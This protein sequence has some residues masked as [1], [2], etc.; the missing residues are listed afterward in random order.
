MRKGATG[1]EERV[2]AE[3]G[4]LLVDKGAVE[5]RWAEYFE[6]LL[7]VEDLNEDEVVIVAVGRED[8]VNVLG[9]INET[10]ITRQEVVGALGGMKAGKAAGMD[11][12]AVECLKAA[13]ESGIEWLVRLLNICFVA[14]AVPLDW[15]SACVV[16]LYKGKGDRFACSSFR[17]ISLLSVV[18]KLYGK[19]LIRRISDSTEGVICEEQCGFRRGR[20]CVDQIFAVRQVCEK[21]LAKGK[22]VFWGFMDLEKAYD[23]I[24]R[25]GLWQ[26]LRLY[27]LGGRLL[28]AVKS[29]Y[30]SSRACVRV[31]DSVSEWFPVRVGL[32]QGCV[33]SPWLFN[34]YMDGVVREVN[35]RILGGG[36]SLENAG[37]E[38]SLKQLLFAD[39]T[40]LVADTEEK[41]GQ[42]V[43]EFGRV[44]RRRKLRVNVGKSKVMR[45][46]RELGGRRLN[47]GLDGEQ[48]EEVDCFKYL[49]SSIA[50]NGRVESEV[51]ARVNEVGKVLGGLKQMFGCRSLRMNVK[52][53][54]YEG[55]AVP[56][57]L[58]GAETWNMGM[59]D[60]KRLDVVE[61]RCLRSM[62]GVTRRDR[63]RNEEVRRRTGVTRELSGRAE[64]SVLKWFGHVERMD[65]NRLVKRI[66]ESDVRGVRL[67][68]RPQ[69][70]WKDGVKRALGSRGLSME[71]GRMIVRDRNEWK[72]SVFVVG[73]G[74][75]DFWGGPTSVASCRREGNCAEDGRGKPA[76]PGPCCGKSN[77]R[78][79]LGSWHHWAVLKG[80]IP[81][82]VP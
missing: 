8:R 14:G 40:A 53:R 31:G 25:E 29:F 71:Q 79:C 27:G 17:G 73:R 52:K 35:A 21:Y 57:A 60:K 55:I 24:D 75:L 28:R 43:E 32:R 50:A 61:M 66:V 46:T 20:G 15:A 49:G 81:Y 3:D 62:C 2:K 59:A 68:G 23:R 56:T 13:G 34:L 11:G 64:Q 51:K 38:W 5:R 45:C 9:E 77:W 65:E 76:S 6:D 30:E 4:T 39:D 37:R 18:G 36:L 33:M 16:P 67:R 41:L 80:E 70:G 69:L 44:C 22:E 12:C 78:H 26:M 48:L 58:Y 54:L 42:L 72:K 63:V 74:F 47:I 7:N 19:V 82:C 10:L 1:K